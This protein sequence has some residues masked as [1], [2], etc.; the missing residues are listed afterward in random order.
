MSEGFA[1]P[2]GKPEKQGQLPAAARLPASPG[3]EQQDIGRKYSCLAGQCCGQS[4]Y[5]C[6]TATQG[7][8]QGLF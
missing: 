3:A 4:L 2:F 6:N 8:L 1:V 5:H 7:P